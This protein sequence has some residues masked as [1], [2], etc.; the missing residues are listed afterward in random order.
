MIVFDLSCGSG[1]VFEAW[2]G[3]SADFEKTRDEILEVMD[4][5]ARIPYVT[6]MGEYYY[7]FW[8]DKAH[9]RG[10]WR[11]TTLAEYRKEHPKWETLIDVDALGKAEGVSWVWEGDN[12]LKPEYRHCLI[13]RERCRSRGPPRCFPNLIQHARYFRYWKRRRCPN[14]FAG[15]LTREGRLH[16]DFLIPSANAAAY[17]RERLARS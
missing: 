14:R 3:S 13:L 11:R 16:F 4:S 7:N 17:R 15:R 6:K 12:C 2:F 9:P 5:D 8:K 10:L 1:H